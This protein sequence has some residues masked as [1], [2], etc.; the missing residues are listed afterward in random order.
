MDS[1]LSLDVLDQQE[2][3]VFGRISIIPVQEVVVAHCVEPWRKTNT[4]GLRHVPVSTMDETF[5][6]ISPLALLL[7]GHHFFLQGSILLS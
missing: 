5:L 6:L 3:A 1:L 7:Y 2:L 4:P